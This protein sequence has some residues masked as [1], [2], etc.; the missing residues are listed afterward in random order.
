MHLLSARDKKRPSTI[1]K[2][3]FVLSAEHDNVQSVTG[4]RDSRYPR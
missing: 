2:S 4:S 3:S 1:R